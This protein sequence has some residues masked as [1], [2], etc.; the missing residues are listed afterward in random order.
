MESR[1]RNSGLQPPPVK[2]FARALPCKAPAKNLP[3]YQKWCS[4][5]WCIRARAKCSPLGEHCPGM[6]E[7]K[8]G[9]QSVSP[10][11]NIAL[12]YSPRGIKSF[13]C[14]R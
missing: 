8:R 10:E 11:E 7:S 3:F 14:I 6:E 9:R 13:S 5:V 12:S 2:H 1:E 4:G